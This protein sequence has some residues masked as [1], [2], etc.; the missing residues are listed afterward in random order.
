MQEQVSG[1]N[2]AIRNHPS[3]LACGAVVMVILTTSACSPL[4]QVVSESPI[5][6]V[7]G[8][9]HFRGLDS[10]AASRPKLSEA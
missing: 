10:R 5:D 6:S 7:S 4:A 9:W 3:R 8:E 2:L 1:L